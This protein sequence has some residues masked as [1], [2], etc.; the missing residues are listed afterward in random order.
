MLKALSPYGRRGC[1]LRKKETRGAG[2]AASPGG[3][4]QELP[5][6]LRSLCTGGPGGGRSCRAVEQM[7]EAFDGGAK[8]RVVAKTALDDLRSMDDG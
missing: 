8:T 1:E 2:V 6:T 5:G 4:S 3:L 7:L